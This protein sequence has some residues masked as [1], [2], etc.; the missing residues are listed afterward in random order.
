MGPGGYR[1]NVSTSQL[2]SGNQ[3]PQV[4]GAGGLELETTLFGSA[5][6]QL[7]DQAGSSQPGFPCLSNRVIVGESESMH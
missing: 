7:L 6:H 2:M 3:W 5:S 4:G 1:N